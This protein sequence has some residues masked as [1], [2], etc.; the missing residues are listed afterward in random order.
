MNSKTLALATLLAAVGAFAVGAYF[1]QDQTRQQITQAAQDHRAALV[2]AHSPV[3]GNAQAKV[4]I[5]E[6]FDPSCETCRAFYPIVKSI[7][8]SSFG[9]VNLVLRYAPLHQGSD[10]AIKILEAARQQDRYWQVLDRVIETQPLWASHANPA[11]ERI[12]DLVADTGLDIA[13]AKQAMQDPAIEQALQQDMADMAAL[14]IAGTPSFFVNGQP[15]PRL[16]ADELQAQV[17]AALSKA[18]QSP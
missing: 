11:P 6:F 1:Y 8:R 4:T 9:E 14:R 3:L 7:I 15:L 18:K 2:R 17:K 13:R 16:G 12:W 5:V 10:V